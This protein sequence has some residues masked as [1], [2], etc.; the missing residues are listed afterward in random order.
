MEKKVRKVEDLLVYQK[1]MK[2]FDDFMEEDLPLL[3]KHFAGRELARQQ[4]RSLDSICANMEEGF[5]RKA[6]PVDTKLSTGQARNI[7]I[8]S[9]YQEVLQ[10]RVKEDTED[11]KNSYL[12]KQSRKE[13]DN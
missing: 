8:S 4:A 9:G 3:S 10:A 12:R 7:K 2:L 11:A 6:G 5:G 1:A 13:W